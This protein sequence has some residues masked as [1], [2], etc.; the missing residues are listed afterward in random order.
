MVS[1]FSRVFSK[2]SDIFAHLLPVIWPNPSYEPWFVPLAISRKQLLWEV[3]IDTTHRFTHAARKVLSQE[4]V[5]CCVL[6][7]RF[8]PIFCHRVHGSFGMCVE[9]TIASH[10]DQWLIWINFREIAWTQFSLP[11]PSKS[12][13]SRLFIAQMMKPTIQSWFWLNSITTHRRLLI[14]SIAYA[15]VHY[16]NAAM[17]NSIHF[18]HTNPYI[19]FIINSFPR[20]S[21]SLFKI[22]YFAGKLKMIP[23]FSETMFLE[24]IL[25]CSAI[26]SR[27]I[28]SNWE[29]WRRCGIFEQ[30]ILYSWSTRESRAKGWA[31]NRI[32]FCAAKLRNELLCIKHRFRPS[33]FL[34]QFMMFKCNHKTKSRK[35]SFSPTRSALTT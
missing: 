7:F 10:G 17:Q 27:R 5:I 12:L 33:G 15:H 24:L 18:I 23:S 34:H 2:S 35:R 14:Y 31:N 30:C 8:S 11:G 4:V 3:W 20:K 29:V 25:F 19:H 21:K 26:Y 22:N 6:P 13:C 9:K 28:V 32:E 16:G 1:F